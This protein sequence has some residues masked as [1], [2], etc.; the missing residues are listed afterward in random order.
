MLVLRFRIVFG[1][2]VAFAHI[3]VLVVGDVWPVVVFLDDF[4][5]TT[6]FRVIEELKADVTS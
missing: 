3:C 5:N 1:T 2:I 4:L 6:L